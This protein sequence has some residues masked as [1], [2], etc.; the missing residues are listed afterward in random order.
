MPAAASRP[1][2]RAT[3]GQRRVVLV[4]GAGLGAPLF[5]WDWES[6]EVSGSSVGAGVPA[7]SGVAVGFGVAE[8]AGVAAGLAVDAGALVAAGAWVAAGRAGR[9]GVGAGVEAGSY[10]E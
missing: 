8:G 2:P 5:C 3:R 6:A 9:T 10:S 7:G 1:A 4:P